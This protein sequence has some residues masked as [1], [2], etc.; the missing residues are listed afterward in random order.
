MPVS[1]ATLPQDADGLLRL[2][3][4]SPERSFVIGEDEEGGEEEQEHNKKVR[5]YL[6]G[7]RPSRRHSSS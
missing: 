5:N 2:Q 4:V 1:P 6:G 3:H 7:R